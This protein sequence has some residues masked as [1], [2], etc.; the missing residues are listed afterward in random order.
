[1]ADVPTGLVTM[2]CLNPFPLTLHSKSKSCGVFRSRNP[3]AGVQ[4][5]AA[6][7]HPPA[8]EDMHRKRCSAKGRAR[9]QAVLAVDPSR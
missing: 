8:E 1:M 3:E 2:A 5:Q 9:S 4:K 6:I 7:G